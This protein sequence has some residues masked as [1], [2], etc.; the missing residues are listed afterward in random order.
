VTIFYPDVSSF[1]SGISLKGALA[2]CCKATEGTNYANSDFPRARAEASQRGVFFFAY[3][4]LHAGNAAAQAKWC[5][6]N[7]GTMS[8]LMLDVEPEPGIGSLPGLSDV[9][10]FLDEYRKLGGIMHL[11]YLPHWYWQLLGSPSLAALVSRG[12]QL[13]SSAYTSYTD[14][15]SGI[16]WQPY[17]GM[18]PVIWQY[19]DTLQ[20]NG[21]TVDFN[22]FRG[23]YAGKQDRESVKACLAELESIARTGKLPAP[24]APHPF[25]PK[26][27]RNPVHGL[28][29]KP[30]TTQTDLTWDA[31]ARAT[32]YR[33]VLRKGL[34]RIVVREGTLTLGTFT[35]LKPGTKYTATVMALPATLWGQL[36]RSKVT[37]T[38]KK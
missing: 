11:V 6:M 23:H 34:R 3:H 15:S 2:A 37:F 24:P 9:L 30:R 27:A 14:S 22:A 31:A 25:I 12:L 33:V 17:G 13:V 28:K 26:T 21:S 16:G 4:F 38:T 35:S 8:P 1:Q 7:V 20:F 10:T 5:F 19:T 36:H 32:G 29:A 18:T